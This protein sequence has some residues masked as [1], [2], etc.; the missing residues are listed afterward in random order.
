MKAGWLLRLSG[1]MLVL[2]PWQLVAGGYAPVTVEMDLKRVSTHVY[3]VQGATGIATDNA[4]FISNAGVVITDAGVVVFDALGTP[5]LAALLLEKIRAI[6]DQPVIKVIVSHYHADHIYGLQVFE[7][8]GAE[9]IAPAGVHE[10]TGSEAAQE[11]L[12]ERRLSLDPWVNDDTRIVEPDQ[13]VEQVDRFTLGGVDF[14]LTALGSAHSDA[15]M[16]LYV[17][18]DRVLFSGDIIFEGRIPFVGNANTRRWMEILEK[19]RASRLA[20]L[21]PGHGGVA[22]DPDEAIGLT[23]RYLSSIRRQMGPAVEEFVP[24]AEAYEAADWSEFAG[25][26]AFDAGHRRN[27]YQVYLSMEAEMLADE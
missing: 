26:P 2:M 11:R 9:I 10:Y 21:I 24:F 7:E 5:S 6:T 18:P 3:Y 15:D 27:V 8:Q 23:W 13:L 25:L 1:L 22:S 14:T 19:M 4:G 12:E 20:A 17:E 16:T